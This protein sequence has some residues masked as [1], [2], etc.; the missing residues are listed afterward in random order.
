MS[1][2][3]T[4]C[5]N[6]IFEYLEDDKSTLYSCLLV[7]R[8]WCE[9]SVRILWRN[10]N[11]YNNRAYSTLISCLSN[12]SKEILSMNNIII[13]IPTT[14]FPTFNYPSF[15]KVL[16]IRHVQCEIK[17]LLKNQQPISPQIFNNI[18]IVVQEICK[19]FINQISSLKRLDLRQYTI[20]QIPIFTSYPEAKDCLRNL[21]ELF[22]DLDTSSEILY[23]LS[24]I[25]HNI[26]LLRINSY[27]LNF[28]LDG[29]VNLI[30]VQKNLKHFIMTQDHG[31]KNIS[32]L[33]TKLPNTLIKLS[34]YEYN[35]VSLSFIAKFSNL[36]ELELSLVCDENFIDFEK[37]SYVSFPQLKI[38]RFQHSRPNNEL[39]IRFLENNGKNLNELYISFE[40]SGY[41][42]NSLN[43]V[44]SKFCTN[45]RKFSGGFKNNE[46]E[47]IL[48]SCKYLKSI[49][50]FCGDK[51]LSEKEALSEVVKYSHENISEIILRLHYCCTQPEELLPKEL[52]SLI[53]GLAN[54]VP[55]RALSLVIVT[56]DHCKESFDKN[57]KNMKVV[58]KYIELGVIKS[59]KIKG[60]DDLFG[61]HY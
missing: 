4:D 1:Q 53:A 30:S 39:L 17:N 58:K 37:L 25:C 56:N 9:I 23:Q 18:N 2:I 42:D 48:K 35:Y 27:N 45:L 49:E 7:N 10:I 22:C 61:M 40:N 26:S 31:V 47:L 15:C 36:Q 59:F 6:D 14:K 44:I 5:L 29:L 43:L 19:M 28:T 46:L 11:N 52:E 55:Q 51:L 16:S 60:Y 3:P 33:I 21:S 38:L 12:E 54:Y 57:E 8:L 34:L 20:M 50:I 13:L 41:N 32:P 24:R